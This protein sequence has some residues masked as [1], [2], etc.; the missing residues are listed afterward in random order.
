MSAELDRDAIA[1]VDTTGQ[2]GEV[3]DLPVHLRD[4]LWRVDSAEIEPHASSGLV[5]AGMGGSAIGGR[6]ACAILGDRAGGPVLSAADYAL[7]PWID[8]S[9]TVLVA[10]YSGSTEETLSCWEAAGRAGARRIATTTGGQ[11]AEDARAAGVPVIP[12]PGGFQPRA[13]VGY[14]TTI[15]LEVARLCGLAPSLRDEI[16]AA[17]VAC[18]SV[19]AVDRGMVELAAAIG[20]RIPLIVGAELTAPVA[21]R[22]KCQINEN[23]KRAAFATALPEHNHNEVEGWD[24]RLVPIL[25]R[26]QDTHP[27]TLERYTITEAVAERAS[28]RS[29]TVSGGGDTRAERLL[30]LVLLGDLMSIYLAVLDGTDPV[31]I[32]AIDYVKASLAD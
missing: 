1:A 29:H 13:T 32:D 4:A 31:S 17:A 8:E 27:R 18:A 16:E 9:W 20:D 6:L 12:I 10:S 26:D 2:L 15:A 3:L 23:A 19:E 5:I 21:Y 24:E 28:G 14:S 7:P 22:W 25:L 30:Q 11:L